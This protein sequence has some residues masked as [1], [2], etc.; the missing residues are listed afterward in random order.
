MAMPMMK[1]PGESLLHR[2]CCR[3]PSDF[4]QDRN[5]G[6]EVKMTKA[7]PITLKNENIVAVTKSNLN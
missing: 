2:P 4:A 7:D 6:V 5:P 3:S 1:I